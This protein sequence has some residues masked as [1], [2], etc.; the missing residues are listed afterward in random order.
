MKQ[1]FRIVIFLGLTPTFG[2]IAQ[3][4]GL[5]EW[6]KAVDQDLIRGWIEDAGIW[7]PV[8]LVTLMTVAIV[9]TPIPSSP[10][11]I[12]AGDAYGHV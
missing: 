1:V 8:L 6:A 11:A 9:A 2:V 10:I 12:A 7:R 4:I 3:T 5:W